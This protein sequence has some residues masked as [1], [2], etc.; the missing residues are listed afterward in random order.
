[1]KYLG[2][3]RQNLERPAMDGR[4]IHKHA[5]LIISSMCRRLSGYTMYQRTQINMISSG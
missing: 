3:H 4:V 1:V 5:A 2:Q